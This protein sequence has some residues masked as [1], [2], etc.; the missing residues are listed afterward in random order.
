[1]LYAKELL[2]CMELCSETG[3]EPVESLWVRH[4]GQINVDDIM[5]GVCYRLPDVVEAVDGAF[6]RRL[7]K[8][9]DHRSW[10]SWST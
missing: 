10:Y 6:F 2:E 8:P 4:R 5:V 7:G 9:C 1:M 3:N